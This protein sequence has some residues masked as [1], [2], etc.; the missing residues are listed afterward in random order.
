MTKIVI[1]RDSRS[2]RA[3]A[4]K[5]IRRWILGIAVLAF[6]LLYFFPILYMILSGFKTEAEAA[7]PSLFFHPTLVTWKKVLSDAAMINYL[8]NT[9]YHVVLG[10]GICL[11]LGIPATYALVFAKF[12]KEGRAESMYDWFVTTILLPPVAV[13]IPLYMICLLYTSPSPRD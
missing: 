13:L 5:E 11:L 2:K 1:L 12:K 8:R 6:A 7:V 10:T 4:K 9:I 3:A